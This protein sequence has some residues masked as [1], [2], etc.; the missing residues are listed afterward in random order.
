MTMLTRRGALK[1]LAGAAGAAGFG[2]PALAA[3][4]LVVGALRFTSHAPSFVALERGYFKEAGLDVE[5]SFF[6]AAQPMA[7]AIA[8]GDVGFGVTAISGGLISLADK[9]AVKVIGGGLQE[10]KGIDGQMILASNAAH[11]DGLTTP[12]GLRGKS[13]GMTTAGSSFHY[14]GSKI[15]AAE[16]FAG[17][18]KMTPLQK[19]G[20]VIG[21][22]KSGQ[23]DAWAIVPHIGKALVGG[24]AAKQIGW[25]ADY[26]PNYQVT[27]VFTSAE[28][29]ANER[30]KTE[31][32]IAA[33]AKG[34][35]DF[36][37]ALVDRTAGDEA[38]EEMTKLIHKYVYADDDYAKAAPKIV[39][40]AMR[41][42]EGA[43]LNI[44]SIEDQLAWFKA[45]ALVSADVTME[46][47]V[48]SSY[49]P[50][51]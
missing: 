47:L 40:G 21:A 42:N 8:S 36:N 26:L 20:A 33:F 14:M 27:T 3:D 18:L 46:T 29:A 31:A 11:E 44:A 25:V 37:A 51:I 6:Q 30:A 2:L 49:V 28:T 48:D 22:L 24:E 5:F 41:M 39:N 23:I 45:E 15:A 10:E 17:E 1:G 13:F 34:A 32:F 7:V 43:A 9:G 50:A 4:K 12:A 35:A 19:V 38:A 16:G